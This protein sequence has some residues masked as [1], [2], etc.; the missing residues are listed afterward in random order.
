MVNK[1]SI[2]TD[3]EA[4][5]QNYI[6]VEKSGLIGKYD[7]RNKIYEEMLMCVSCAKTDKLYGKIPNDMFCLMQKTPSSICSVINKVLK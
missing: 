3:G 1:S 6:K 2:N 5:F 7:K 4:I